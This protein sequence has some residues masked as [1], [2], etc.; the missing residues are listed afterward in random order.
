MTLK[1]DKGI[2][3]PPPF[4]SKPNYPFASMEV[5]DSFF[6]TAKWGQQVAAVGSQR[7]KPKRFTARRAVSDAG[8][9]WRIWRVE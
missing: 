9:G 8:T 1:I 4:R 6:T 7:H 3:I 2:P 5:G